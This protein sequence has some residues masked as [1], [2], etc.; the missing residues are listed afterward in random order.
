MT[1]RSESVKRT[2]V[3]L[4]FS[5]FITLNSCKRTIRLSLPKSSDEEAG[6]DSWTISQR[7]RP[8]KNFGEHGTAIRKVMYKVPD[9]PK[10]HTS[11]IRAAASRLSE[12]GR[13]ISI[14]DLLCH[15]SKSERNGSSEPLPQSVKAVKLM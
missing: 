3:D 11:P 7:Y 10:E 1:S 6:R 12:A 8:A 15:C 13:P 4:S 5:F 9:Y 14:H 2:V